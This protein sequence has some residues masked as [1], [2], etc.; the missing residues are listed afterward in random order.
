MQERKPEKR[1]EW[2]SHVSARQSRCRGNSPSLYAPAKSYDAQHVKRGCC[3]WILRRDCYLPSSTHHDS[4]M[5]LMVK[6]GTYSDTGAHGKETKYRGCMYSISCGLHGG[7]VGVPT[8]TQRCTYMYVCTCSYSRVG[9]KSAPKT[10]P[11]KRDFPRS[12]YHRSG[13]GCF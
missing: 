1:P 8:C 5:R 13:P 10:E 2:T 9:V 12:L 3:L 6:I 4:S 7:R 11:A